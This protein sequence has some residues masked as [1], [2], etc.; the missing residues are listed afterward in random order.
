MKQILIAPLSTPK[1]L[2][3]QVMESVHSAKLLYLQTAKHPSA[4]PVLDAGL[5]FFSMDELY[6]AAK[7]FDALN[8]AIADRLTAGPSC[9]YAVMGDGCYAQLAAI[10]RAAAERGFAVK[11]LPAVSFSKAAFPMEQSALRLSARELPARLEPTLPLLIEEI[12]TPLT[13]GELKLRLMKTYPEALQ[14]T[15]ATLCADGSYRHRE[16]PLYELDRGTSYGSGTVLLVPPVPFMQREHYDYEALVAVMRRLREPD[17]CPWD[18]EQTHESIRRDLIEECYELIGAID[19]KSDEHMQEELGDVLMQVV[20][21]AEIAAEQ[22]R[23]DEG[24]VCSGIVQKLIYRHPHVFGDVQVQSSDEVLKNWDALKKKEKQQ[25]SV[26]EIM[27]AISPSFPALL[28][29]QKVQHKAHKAGFDWDNAKEAFPKIREETDELEAA[30]AGEGD[31]KEEL[32]DLLFAAVNV[33]RLLGLDAEEALHQAT[34][35]FIARYA[36]MEELARL[37]GVE[38]ANKSLSEQDLYWKKAKSR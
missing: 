28:Q 27:Q 15:L 12:D 22:G 32:G 8:D 38:L 25:N 6:D 31:S 19:E 20:F 24:D 13:A 14:V 17:G 33:A 37:D 34:A 11:L 26:S 21:H 35:K 18:R 7:D 4:K 16:L 23:F 10:R 2:S 3:A 30:M 29:A 36:R 1:T 9:V 5:A